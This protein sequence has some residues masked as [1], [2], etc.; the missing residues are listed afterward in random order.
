MYIY[1]YGD[2]NEIGDEGIDYL[3]TCNEMGELRLLNA[4]NFVG[5]YVESNGIGKMG[6]IR[7]VQGNFGN[8]RILVMGIMGIMKVIIILVVEGSNC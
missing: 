5:I 2:G 6:L 8:L 1:F 3:V 7:V 4:G